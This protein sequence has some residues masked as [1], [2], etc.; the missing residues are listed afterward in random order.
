MSKSEVKIIIDGDSKDFQKALDHATRSTKRANKAIKQTKKDTKDLGKTFSQAANQVTIFNGQLDPI[1]GRLSAIG[2]GIARFGALSIVGAAGIGALALSIG[3]AISASEEYEMRQNRFNALLEATSNQ[4]RLTRVELEGLA[5]AIGRDTLSSTEEAEKAIRVMLTF[6][7][8]QGETFKDSIKL[9]RDMQVAMGTDLRSATLQ[10]GKAL[11]DPISNM[12]ALSRAGVQ[13][14]DAQKDMISAMWEV[15]DV[16]GSQAIILKELRTQVGGLAEKEGTELANSMDL[17]GHKWDRMWESL[18]RSSIIQWYKSGAAGGMD[19]LGEL[20]DGIAEAHSEEN[21]K[22]REKKDLTDDLFKANKK[23]VEKQKELKEAQESF[24]VFGEVGGGSYAVAKGKQELERAEKELADVRSKYIQWH[25]NEKVEEFNQQKKLDNAKITATKETLDQQA[26]LVEKNHEKR[27]IAET[28]FASGFESKAA[29]INRVYEQKF[30]KLKES[31]DKEEQTVKLRQKTELELLELEGGTE[32]D[33]VEMVARHRQELLDLKKSFEALEIQGE[34][35]RQKKLNELAEREAARLRAD[36]LRKQRA[37][38]KFANDQK[39]LF[40]DAIKIS[41][42]DSVNTLDLIFGT[43]S[44]LVTRAQRI[45]QIYA[46]MIQSIKDS[47]QSDEKKAAAIDRLNVEREKK[48]AETKAEVRKKAAAD[49][50]SALESLGKTGNKKLFAISKAASIAKAVMNTYQ[51][52][53]LALANIPPPFGQIAAGINIAA[54]LA[55]VAQIRAQQMPQFHDG[56]DFVPR[57]GSYL[58]E[59]GE[60][61]VDSRLNADLRSYLSNQASSGNKGDIYLQIP[62]T[63]SYNAT[64][65]WFEDYKYDIKRF[66]LD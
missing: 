48:I 36:A 35:G 59:K 27:L 5:N 23:V 43:E 7:K 15:G 47:D 18:G 10:L 2:T 4:S 58:I 56:I 52:A 63:G 1:S 42:A 34:E 20:M 44:E 37:I 9:A 32:R 16:A 53:T 41:N 3:K 64:E 60:R 28:S 57:T 62:D 25:M 11:N 14:T 19:R 55:N 29:K 65:Q 66:I 31:Y 50:W 33:R 39:R 12:G 8:V 49:T 21:I 51:S 26:K 24:A 40:K 54:G 30:A 13:F 61:V 6:K 45:E 38:E 22:I 46:Q 17:L